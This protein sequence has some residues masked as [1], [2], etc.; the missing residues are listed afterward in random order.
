MVDNATYRQ[1]HPEDSEIAPPRNALGREAMDS[2]KPPADPFVLLL[3]AHIRG[4][5]MHNKKWSKFFPG[6]QRIEICVFCD[7]LYLHILGQ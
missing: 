4:Y 5:G 6:V 2:D 3:P 1:M 7:D